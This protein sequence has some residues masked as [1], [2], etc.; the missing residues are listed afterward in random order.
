MKNII[1]ALENAIFG[2]RRL[3]IGV[4][5]LL[6][7]FMGYSA[8]HLKIDAGFKKLLPL[9]H[10]Y[11][12][13]FVK[14]GK[15]FGG[16]NR[17][18]IALKAKDG[19]IYSKEFFEALGQA[20]DEVF[21]IPGVDRS[22][23]TSLFTPNVR[24]TEVTEE[25]FAGGKVVPADFQPTAEGLET[26]RK[27]VL[28]SNIIGR[29]VANDFSAAII[30][31]ELME[32]NPDTGERLN[33]LEVANLLEEVRTKFA[34][35][36]VDVHIIG[37]AKFIGDMT[38]GAKRVVLFFAIA[39]LISAFLVRWYTQSTRATVVLLTCSVMAVVLQLGLLP[40]LGFGIDPMSI[41]VPFLVFAIAISHGVQM[42]GATRSEIFLG[43]GSEEAAR[44]SFRRLL[45]PGGIA[46]ASDTIGFITILLI[47]IQIIQEMAI[48][49]S[50]GVAMIIFAN[51]ILL[52]VLLSYLSYSDAYKE[53]TRVRA[54]RMKKIWDKVGRVAEPKPALI[55]LLVSAVLLTFAAWKGAD[56]KIGDLERGV[57]ELRAESRYNVDGRVI[58]DHF[59][60]G[61]DVISIIAETTPDACIEYDNMSAIDDF[62]WAMK[63]VP[64]VQSVTN[65]S[66][67]AKMVNSGWNEGGLNWRMIPRNQ[68]SLV[69]AT[70]L[71]PS[72]S[73]LLNKDCSVMPLLI[74]TEDHKAE[75]ITR[76]VSAVKQ[77]RSDNPS[78]LVN[79]QLATGNV[80]VMAA[81]NEEVDAAQ[82]PILLYVFA[83][84]IILCYLSFRSIRGVLCIVLPLGMVSMF[85]YALMTMNNIGLK[86]STLPV[87]AL[88]VGVGVDYGIY[89]FSR[90]KGFMDEGHDLQHAYHLTLET[91]GNAVIFTGV[92][93]AIG[94]ATWIFSPL[95][96]QADMG[97]LLTFM[98]LVNMLGAILV[99][100]A[101]A[102]WMM[103][104]KHK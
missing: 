102:C 73:G 87:V 19:D 63:N 62:A 17:V 20:T 58:S 41:L 82:F 9:E 43:S 64:G 81:T 77:Y 59:S 14:H 47:K 85:G 54:A 6:A 70:R 44:K 60:I 36:K 13:T 12:Q 23:V 100:P 46:L 31:A 56:I 25:G 1:F 96:F 32:I 93:L 78:E 92:T 51:L 3:V 35:D 16:A 76:I 30:S 45:I 8:T 91:T 48:T 84:I 95:Q 52:P 97:V 39:F 24:F 15:E 71:I 94:V 98:F 53:K 67:A 49:A 33:Y 40:L 29:L 18:L 86:V 11:M 10:E 101:L 42:I 99:L 27:N 7:I 79:F 28:K 69:Q 89:I 61:V 22:K 65:L 55:V 68:T 5:V 26:V 83:A 34:N 75:T 88:G 80:G 57:P 38:D 37:F 4:F 50:L 21:F 74:F 72:S 103:R 104:D 2:H 90:F 66:G